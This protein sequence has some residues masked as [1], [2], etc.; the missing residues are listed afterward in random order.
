MRIA[1]NARFLLPNKLEGI[2]YFTYEV[3]KRM[4]AAH[5]EHDYILFFDRPYH[6]QFYF[7]D[8]VKHIVLFPQARHPFLFVWW[9]EWAVARAL[10][11]HKVDVFFSPDNFLTLNTNVP[12][13]LVVHD[14]AYAHFSDNSSWINRLYYHFFTPRF[15]K[16]AQHILTVSEFTKQDLL[17]HFPFLQKEK[18]TVCYNGCRD[19]FIENTEGG[20]EKEFSVTE[21][22][23]FLYV[24]AV[25]PRKNVHRLI[26]AFDEY[27]KNTKSDTKLVICGRFAWKTGAVKT[28][29][30]NSFFKKDIIFTGYMSDEKVALLMASA[31]AVVYVSLFEGFGVPLLEAMNCNVPIITSNVTSMPEVAGDAAI[32]VNPENIE[33][34]A[35][36]MV[37]IGKDPILRQKL[38]ENGQKQR[39]KF[40]WEKTTEIVFETIKKAN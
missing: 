7:G 17:L 20:I 34:I 37:T 10:K 12:S 19:I 3:V 11:E 38:V 8:K 28:A 14:I 31:L 32:L 26:Q 21:K 35:N 29:F 33:D 13:V 40:D 6:S 30:D 9:F 18:M 2:G 5:P 39:I 25:H 1:I 23:Y 15:V 27:K 24:G 22:P 36:A 4:I 16:K